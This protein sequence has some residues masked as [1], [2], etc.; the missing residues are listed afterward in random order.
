MLKELRFAQ[1]IN[2]YYISISLPATCPESIDKQTLINNDKHVQL[3]STSLL[4][5]PIR[6][7]SLF[8]F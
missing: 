8:Y 1:A 3:N 5:I 6:A 4:T 7:G 2:S